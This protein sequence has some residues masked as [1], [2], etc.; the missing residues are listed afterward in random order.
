MLAK[1]I[2]PCLDVKDG[3]VVKGVNFVGLRDAGDPVELARFYSQ[4]GADEIVF[5]D[6]T[7]TSDARATIAD[8]V[9]RTCREVFVPVTVGG[10]IRTVDDFRDILRAGADKISINS[11]A[12]K[13]P[14]LVSEAAQKYGSQCVVVAIDGRRTGRTLSGFEVFVAGGRTP[15]GIDAVQWA[16]D[17]YAA[18][19]GEILLT[20]MD[21]DGTKSGF[22][23]EL[24]GAVCQ[25]VGIPVIASGGCGSLEHF[26]QVFQETGA[27]AALAASLFHYGELTVSQVKRHLQQNNIPVRI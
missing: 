26:S 2:I 9:R 27:D 16:K 15:T 18:G 23:L 13:N 12:V 4:Q 14:A 21:K 19:A 3:R 6:I 5:L 22:D 8:V 17:V 11:A 10:G 25:A 7:A 24:T 20:S 1:R